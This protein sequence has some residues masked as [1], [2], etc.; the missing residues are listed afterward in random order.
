MR[1]KLHTQYNRHTYL[2]RDL[3]PACTRVSA[4]HRLACTIQVK[5]K[6]MSINFTVIA[7]KSLKT[8][9]FTSNPASDW[10]DRLR[11][12]R[13]DTHCWTSGSA[14]YMTGKLPS[15]IQTSNGVKGHYV[16]VSFIVTVKVSQHLNRSQGFLY[17]WVL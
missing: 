3:E 2:Q 1:V 8:I 6:C 7:K 12:H 15:K 17:N 9:F 14:R 11:R 4:A 13:R 10:S 16:S 5:L